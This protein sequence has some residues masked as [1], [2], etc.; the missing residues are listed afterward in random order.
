MNICLLVRFVGGGFKAF[1]ENL[2]SLLL[3]HNHNVTILFLNKYEDVNVIGVK[4]RWFDLE[5]NS[6]FQ[7]HKKPYCTRR[8]IERIVFHFRHLNPN[9]IVKHKNFHGQVSSEWIVKYCY[10]S[11]DLTEFDCVVSTEEKLCN[12]FLAN[13]VVAKRKVGYVHPDYILAH[14]DKKI[15]YKFFKKLDFIC[16]VSEANA[17]S[18]KKTFPTIQNKIKG[19]RNVINI[20]MILKR[21]LVDVDVRYNNSTTNIVTVCRLDNNSKALDRLLLLAKKLKDDKLDFVWRVIG[22]GEY[23]QEMATFIHNYHLEDNIILLGYMD[24]PLPYVKSSDLFVLQSYYE[25]FPISVCESI[26]LNVPVLVTNYPSASEQV[27]SGVTGYIVDNNFEL[28]YLKLKNLILNKNLLLDAK[29]NLLRY[30][31]KDFENIDNFL[32]VCGYD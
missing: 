26:I 18:L 11:L 32:K 14:F 27:E 31:K 8:F 3:Q 29:Q 4:K 5:S 12:Y 15:D 6:D 10:A 19:V 24:N 23:E 13:N 20:D 28:I 25:G 7:L 16:A 9:A 17:N 22:N 1:V 30:D 21:S 2:S